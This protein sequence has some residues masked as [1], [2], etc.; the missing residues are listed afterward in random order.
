M[1]AG[2]FA[3]DATLHS[4]GGFDFYGLPFAGKEVELLSS[5]LPAT[6]ALVDERF[7][8]QQVLP[9]I[10]R[11]NILHFATHAAFL[12]G[13]PAESFILFGN[14]DAPTLKDIETWPLADVDL[15]VLSAC[16]TGLGGFD[17][18]GEQ[19]LGLGYQFQKRGAKAVI[20]SLWLVNDNSTQV[21]MNGFYSALQQ[22]M[23]KSE[24]LRQAQI[25]LITDDYTAVGGNRGV[26]VVSADTGEPLT[27]DDLSHPFYWA[28]FI[29]I[30]NGL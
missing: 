28:P 18:N 17:N 12:P 26:Q 16:E 6:T 5:T 2:A 25:A 13:D 7:G 14:G 29:L 27:G 8:L 10:G 22:G 19:I 1:L 23:P 20:A 21:L 11:F 9:E 4:V 3:D 15:V 24:A 30:G